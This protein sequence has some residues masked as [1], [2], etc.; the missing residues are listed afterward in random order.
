MSGTAVRRMPED[1]HTRQAVNDDDSQAATRIPFIFQP[2]P[3]EL[4]KN[5]RQTGLILLCRQCC[6]IFLA[7]SFTERLLFV[8]PVAL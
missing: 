1:Q 2:L 6:Y 7:L 8:F 4:N 3:D 5:A